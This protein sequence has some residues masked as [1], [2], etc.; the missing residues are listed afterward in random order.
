MRFLDLPPVLQLHLKRFEYDFQRDCQIKINDRYEFPEDLDLSPFLSAPPPTADG[1]PLPVSCDARYVL[2]SVLVH[3]GGASGGHYYAFVRPDPQGKP[4]EWLKF[5]DERVTRENAERAV[6]DNYGEGGFEVEGVV[7]DSYSYSRWSR[8]SNAYMLVYVRA[9]EAA[10]VVC[11]VPKSAV[12]EHVVKRLDM[13]KADKARARA[14]AADAHLHTIVKLA[15]AQDIAAHV[16]ARNG[17]T[18]FGLVNWDAPSLLQLRVKDAISLREL[19]VAAAARFPPAAGARWW[20]WSRRENGTM[21][22]DQALEAK[23]ETATVTSIASRQTAVQLPR[24]SF[25][26]APKSKKEGDLVLFLELYPSGS[27]LPPPPPAKSDILLFIKFY[28][29]VGETLT[30]LGPLLL[31]T[32]QRVSDLAAAVAQLAAAHLPLAPEL[33][34][35]EEIRSEPQ[36]RVDPLAD[37]QMTLKVRLPVSLARR[38]TPLAGC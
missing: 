5:D 8:V 22:V 20:V 19:R 1:P 17:D 34:L 9:S 30:F 33:L 10:R 7:K 37:L 6:Q 24:F 29:P 36:V 28:D 4:S 16:S 38:L 21:R 18:A 15:T 32:S 11:E 23:D 27:V 35:F 26:S 2:H 14:E 12:P 13:E 25:Y 3:S 31:P